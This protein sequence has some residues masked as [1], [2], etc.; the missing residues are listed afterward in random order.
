MR[1]GLVTF[2][3]GGGTGIQRRLKISTGGVATQAN[4][5]HRHTLA[6]IARLAGLAVVR[7][8]AGILAAVGPMGAIL[9]R[10]I[11][12]RRVS[13]HR[14]SDCQ[15]HVAM[16]R[17]PDGRPSLRRHRQAQDQA[18]EQSQRRHRVFVPV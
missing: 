1:E 16:P 9:H 11:M 10:L 13:R 4:G 3:A 15:A 12:R 18:E 2:R 17:R 8:R 7:C 14:L 6:V 5:K